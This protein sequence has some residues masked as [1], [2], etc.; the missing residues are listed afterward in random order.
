MFKDLLLAG[1]RTYVCRKVL[2]VQSSISSQAF[3]QSTRLISKKREETAY[4]LFID[5]TYLRV[6]YHPN[7]NFPTCFCYGGI[8]VTMFYAILAKM[9]SY[10]SNLIFIEQSLEQWQHQYPPVNPSIHPSW[11]Q[12]LSLLFWKNHNIK[13]IKQLQLNNG[14]P[15]QRTGV[16]CQ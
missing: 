13:K 14:S 8:V 4:F 10:S 1:R 2:F 11:G 5:R 15:W 3:K 7:T 16:P 12:K 9:L 6:C